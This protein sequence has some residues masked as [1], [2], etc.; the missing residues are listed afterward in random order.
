MKKHLI[1]LISAAVLALPLTVI[2]T[3]AAAQNAAQEPFKPAAQAQ[4]LKKKHAVKT[5]TKSKAKT[6][7]SAKS[8]TKAG[9]VAQHKVKK[10]KVAKAKSAHAKSKA[11]KTV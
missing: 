3:E 11:N 9:K 7:A 10:H 5:S 1:S 2:S 4:P 8:K 6:H